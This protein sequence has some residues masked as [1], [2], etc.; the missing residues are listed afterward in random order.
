[1]H[2]AIQP[3]S[4]LPSPL[5]ADPNVSSSRC[6]R[7]TKKCA[8]LSAAVM[9]Y[10]GTGAMGVTIALGIL[11]VGTTEMEKAI[12]TGTVA[13]RI[14]TGVIFTT[15]V[16]SG[17]GTLIATGLAQKT[18]ISKA[19]E[20]TA[21]RTEEDPRQQRSTL[22]KTVGISEAEPANRIPELAT[23][24]SPP[25]Q[26]SLFPHRPPNHVSLVANSLC[27]HLPGIINCCFLFG[28]MYLVFTV[29]SKIMENAN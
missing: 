17:V 7:P 3:R 28:S 10:V 6:V 9:V 11:A 2:G 1:M 4:I 27:N 16:A 24:N 8:I 5:Q 19:V 25:S 12:E 22:H 14:R 13:G 29:P 26:K 18:I 21:K 20:A 15:V 23:I